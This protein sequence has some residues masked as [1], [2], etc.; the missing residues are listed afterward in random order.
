MPLLLP[1][2]ASA[3]SAYLQY[4]GQK[5]QN[6]RDEAR[7][8]ELL[9]KNKAEAAKRQAQVEGSFGMNPYQLEALEQSRSRQGVK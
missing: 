9:K 8:K 6:E 5:K 7:N 4:R 1:F 2:L 3:G